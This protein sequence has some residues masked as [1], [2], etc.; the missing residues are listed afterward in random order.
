MGR[1][2]FFSLLFSFLL[3]LLLFFTSSFHSIPFTY[4]YRHSSVIRFVGIY[5]NEHNDT[6]QSKIMSPFSFFFYFILHSHITWT[7]CYRRL[8]I[9]NKIWFKTFML[10]LR[11]WLM[12]MC[13]NLFCSVFLFLRVVLFINAFFSKE[14]NF[15]GHFYFIYLL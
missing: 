5:I 10:F 1:K 2:V 12:F 8:F 13:V 15:L 14:K 7:N 3:L 11:Q 6:I 9:S 4:F